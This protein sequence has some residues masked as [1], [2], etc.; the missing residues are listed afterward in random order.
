MLIYA[1]RR[2][3]L[4]SRC[5]SDKLSVMSPW[6]DRSHPK[7]Y[8]RHSD[9]VGHEQSFITF[10]E[11][12]RALVISGHGLY[13]RYSDRGTV[14][15]SDRSTSDG[16]R[17]AYCHPFSLILV[18]KRRSGDPVSGR[19]FV[20]RKYVL[21][22]A[23]RQ[24]ILLEEHTLSRELNTTLSMKEQA[25]CQRANGEYAQISSRRCQ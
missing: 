21:F 14:I 17:C 10:G 23:I 2:T 25:C 24:V 3:N 20:E 12:K 9:L 7:I 18:R 15:Q 16:S 4:E 1:S 22:S 13:P 5:T 8:G 11:V 19:T 6:R